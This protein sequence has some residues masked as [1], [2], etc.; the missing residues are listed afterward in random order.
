MTSASANERS[1]VLPAGSA[2]GSNLT[3]ADKVA[4]VHIEN[5]TGRNLTASS[6][7]QTIT[8]AASDV[9]NDG[10]VH[11]RFTAAPVLEAP[12]HPQEQQPYFFIEITKGATSLFHTFN[13]A[14]ESGVPWQSGTGSIQYTDW[15]AFDIP[16]NP[17]LVTVGDQITLKVI[18]AG[19]GQTGHAGAVYVNNVRTTNAVT[20]SSLWVTANGP[21][22]AQRHTNPDGSTDITYTYTYTNNGN[23][24]VNNVV[25]D[26]TMPVDTSGTTTTFVGIGIPTNGTCTGPAAGLGSTDP[27]QCNIGT[28]APGET[29]T[30]TMT[31]RVPAGTT[32]DQVNNGTYPIQGTNVPQL[33]GPLVKTTLIADLVPNINN[34][35]PNGGTTGTAYPPN[36]SFSC[37]NQGSTTA[38]GNTVCQVNNLPPGVTVGQCTVAVPPATPGA[39]WSA[40]QAVPPA[41]VG[42]CPV[43]GTPT[44][45]APGP[46]EGV[47]GS[48]NEPAGPARD[49]NTVTQTP[50]AAAM[51]V[52]T[53]GE[54]G[55]MLMAG[56]LAALGFSARRKQG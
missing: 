50:H 33:L 44:G 12:S 42:T 17:A 38:S 51:P 5:S 30:F 21:A 37:T 56:M 29:G 8:I 9:D 55:M 45:Q 13:F 34:L 32:A 46:L 22:E 3:W 48:D 20:G 4:R 40:G 53:L 7:E 10:R 28:L 11:V 27:A 39:N 49:N 54:W 24:T 18:A 25:V 1:A 31:V 15:Q 23:T 52:P 19:C 14:N 36:A 43:S 16:L 41:G 26:P 2:V 47:T 6:I 35:P